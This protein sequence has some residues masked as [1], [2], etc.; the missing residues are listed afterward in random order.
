MSCLRFKYVCG[1][2]LSSWLISRQGL[3]WGGFSHV[4]PMLPDGSHIDARSDVIH[5]PRGGWKDAAGNIMAQFSPAI[6]SGIQHR[7]PAYE[8]WKR[9]VIVEVDCSADQEA[10]AYGYMQR[11]IGDQYDKA[12]IGAF[13]FGFAM[14]GRGRAICSAF[15]LDIMRYVKLT[16]GTFIKTWEVPPNTMFMVHTE[17][18]GARAIY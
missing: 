16:K 2:G 13:I 6:P 14:H 9:E 7:P 11:H 5:A 17:G 8:D 10:D 18:M 15:T 4:A 12:A 1:F 3:S